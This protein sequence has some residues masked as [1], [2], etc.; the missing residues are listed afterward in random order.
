MDIE[1][2]LRMKNWTCWLFVSLLLVSWANVQAAYDCRLNSDCPA[3]QLCNGWGQ[4]Y[5]PPP[6]GTPGCCSTDADC[7][8]LPPKACDTDTNTCI[9]PDC[10]DSLDCGLGEVCSS[11]SCIVDVMADRDYDGVPDGSDLLPVDNCTDLSNPDQED[12]DGDGQGDA[13]DMDMDGDSV[14]NEWD[15]CPRIANPSQ[16]DT[17][18][19]DIGNH[20]EPQQPEECS[21][22]LSGG[23]DLDNDGIT[24]VCDKCKYFAS[25]NNFDSDNDGFG[26]VCDPDADGDGRQDHED[27]CPGI[28]NANQ[29][30]C[31]CNAMGDA[32]DSFPCDPA[33]CNLINNS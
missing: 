8:M 27:N 21:S 7:D 11:A 32:C 12:L 31:N 26:D 4:C 18:S 10:W 13:C 22:Y 24:D 19:N 28:P 29:A 2:V 6:C 25:E 23:A 9:V 20:C 33:A 30:D 15:N 14:N 16:I 17:D 3:G 1:K 5:V